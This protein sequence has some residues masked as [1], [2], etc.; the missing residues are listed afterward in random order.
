[1]VYSSILKIKVTYSSETS[2]NFQLIT[3]RYISEGITLH[4]HRYGNLRSCI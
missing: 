1:L 2:V 4:N 3:R